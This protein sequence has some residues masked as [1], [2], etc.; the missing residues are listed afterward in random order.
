MQA[1]SYAVAEPRREAR[2]LNVHDADIEVAALSHPWRAHLRRSGILGPM[3]SS[4]G[5]R[6]TD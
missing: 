3:I 4:D 1:P 6:G 2:R 5:R